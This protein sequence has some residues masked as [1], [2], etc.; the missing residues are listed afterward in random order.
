MKQ[1]RFKMVIATVLMA[2]IMLSLCITIFDSQTL[3]SFAET[4][5]EE[6]D[7]VS[8]ENGTEGDVEP[9]GLFTSLSL[10]IDCGGGKVWATVKNDFTLFPATVIVIVQLYSSDTYAESYTEMKLVCYN[11]INDLN[12][13]QT[14]RTEASTEGK[15]QYWNARMRYKIDSKEWESKET[16]VCRI[17]GD[18][19]FLGYI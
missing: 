14:V 19:N 8:D 7:I 2:I 6:V 1:L 10:S 3:N 11:S 17:D 5:V 13:G 15:T 9:Y 12:I 16:G 4:S 18:G